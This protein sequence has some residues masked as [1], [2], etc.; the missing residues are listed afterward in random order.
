MKLRAEEIEKQAREE[1][2]KK[3]WWRAVLSILGAMAIF[4]L[5]LFK[6]DLRNLPV[7]LQVVIIIP[8]VLLVIF[9]MNWWHWG[10]DDA[11][12]DALKDRIDRGE[13]VERK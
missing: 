9:L 10:E 7:W 12:R 13:Q 11:A 5:F 6:I 4:M 1:Y 3:N 2:N 8:T